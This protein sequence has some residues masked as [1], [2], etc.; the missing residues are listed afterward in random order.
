LGDV[1]LAPI[2][3]QVGLAFY[4]WASLAKSSVWPLSSQSGQVSDLDIVFLFTPGL[5]NLPDLSDCPASPDLPDSPETPDLPDC[6]VCPIG[7]F[8]RIARLPRLPS[9]PDCPIYPSRPISRIAVVAR[10]ARYSGVHSGRNV[11]RAHGHISEVGEV[12]APAH[13]NREIDLVR[14]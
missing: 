4:C 6:P 3:Q 14:A 13:P 1:D 11:K 12:R 2:W 10:R 8:S 9:L 7:Q 5:S